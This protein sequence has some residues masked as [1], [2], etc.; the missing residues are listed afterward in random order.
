M[1]RLR[2]DKYGLHDVQVEHDDSRGCCGCFAKGVR[3]NLSANKDS[4]HG[5]SSTPALR[6]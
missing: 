2:K 1:A 3:R 5:N 6:T 4:C